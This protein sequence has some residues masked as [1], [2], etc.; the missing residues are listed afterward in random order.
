MESSRG[1]LLS[2]G[3]QALTLAFI[4]YVGEQEIGRPLLTIDSG[5]VFQAGL[6]AFLLFIKNH[7]KTIFKEG[8]RLALVSF[9][10]F[11]GLL[12]PQLSFGALLM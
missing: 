7:A 11:G 3:N 6:A 1:G 12:W 10:F 5:L 8:P 9:L 2:E 4:L